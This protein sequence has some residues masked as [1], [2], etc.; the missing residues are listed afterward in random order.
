MSDTGKK[1]PIVGEGIARTASGAAHR[2]ECAM[3]TLTSFYGGPF[4][5]FPDLPTP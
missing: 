2:F 5:T 4:I 1:L 3:P